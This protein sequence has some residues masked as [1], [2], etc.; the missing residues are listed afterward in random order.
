MHIRVFLWVGFCFHNR[1]CMPGYFRNADNQYS[2]LLSGV[3]NAEQG[4][5]SSGRW[6]N[7]LLCWSGGDFPAAAVGVLLASGSVKECWLDGNSLIRS[8]SFASSLD[9]IPALEKHQQKCD[10]HASFGND[11]TIRLPMSDTPHIV[12]SI[13][14]HWVANSSLLRSSPPN[15]ED[16]LD[17]CPSGLRN[18]AGSLL[19]S[20][21]RR[22]ED[23]F[24]LWRA[25]EPFEK[26]LLGSVSVDLSATFTP[27]FSRAM[28]ELFSLTDLLLSAT[29]STLN[30]VSVNWTGALWYTA[31]GTAL[32]DRGD[33]IKYPLRVADHATTVHYTETTQY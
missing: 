21:T 31:T 25:A 19:K 28:G 29:L 33:S 4:C 27:S 2:E 7:K 15:S 1:Q 13:T 20:E 30:H 26:W 16:K 10:Q 17:L 5:S 22:T 14:E 12:V 32:Y 23:F 8:F 18:W 3:L 6:C 11:I 24:E 9:V